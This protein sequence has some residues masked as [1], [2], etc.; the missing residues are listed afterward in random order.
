M[1]SEAMMCGGVDLSEAGPARKELYRI[2]T[3]AECERTNGMHMGYDAVSYELREKYGLAGMT[4]QTC[5]TTKGDLSKVD[6][7]KGQ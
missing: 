7:L 1:D 3:R 4:I 2:V 6:A 5:A